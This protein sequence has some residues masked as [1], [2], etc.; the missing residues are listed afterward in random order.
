MADLSH[1][2]HAVFVDVPNVQHTRRKGRNVWR[3]VDRFDWR[4]LADSI[5]DDLAAPAL[6]STAYVTKERGWKPGGGTSTNGWRQFAD[7]ELQPFGRVLD[8]PYKDV[9]VFLVNDLWTHA[10]QTREDGCHDKIRHVL[11]SGD[12]DYLH[13][14]V[15]LWRI[16]G[17]IFE[18]ELVVY[19]WKEKLHHKLAQAAKKI[20]YLD[21][22]PGFL[23]T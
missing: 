21:D 15:A 8:S 20:V 18:I 2:S 22:L 6:N 4:V 14:Y 7:K 11:V 23:K 1:M 16:Y 19:S 12:G 9:D 17:S 5:V 3:P 10:A 13:A